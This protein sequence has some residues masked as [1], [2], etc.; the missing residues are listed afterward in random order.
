MKKSAVRKHPRGSAAYVVA[1]AQ[2]QASRGRKPSCSFKEEPNPHKA[3]SA[4]QEIVRYDL[5]TRF[6][7]FS[8]E[9][10]LGVWAI[11][12]LPDRCT[13]EITPDS[14]FTRQHSYD[15]TEF[16][17]REPAVYEQ[18]YT[19]LW[20]AE[21][22]AE[23]LGEPHWFLLD[24]AEIYIHPGDNVHALAV[25]W[26]VKNT[27]AW[28]DYAAEDRRKIARV[29]R[30][31]DKLVANLPRLDFSDVRQP[32]MF[33]RHF[34]SAMDRT[35]VIVDRETPYAVFTNHGFVP[36]AE[37]MDNPTEEDSAALLADRERY[38][39]YI[40]GQGLSGLKDSWGINPNMMY[41][42]T[43]RWLE[44]HEASA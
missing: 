7:A 24:I 13:L 44:L 36:D 35:G 10:E 23:S 16:K 29:Q 34:A 27:Q 43:E 17:Q 22:L 4:A 14:N 20:M 32:L 33:M 19:A 15:A 11:N 1:H 6:R 18:V 38:A 8:D 25:Q 40:I 3:L 39:R 2:R 30:K 31:A 37:T 26:R 21:L 12:N 42:S 28:R 9:L 5:A 41:F